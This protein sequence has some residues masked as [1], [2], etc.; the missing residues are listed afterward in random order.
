MISD[1]EFWLKDLYYVFSNNFD[2]A[3]HI[4]TKL[5]FQVFQDYLFLFFFWRNFSFF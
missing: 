4:E 2:S 1:K 3:P 5:G